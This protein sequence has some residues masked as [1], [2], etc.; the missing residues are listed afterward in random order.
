MKKKGLQSFQVSRL[1]LSDQVAEQIQHVIV[2]GGLRPGDKLPSE[3]ELGEQLGVS[4][5]VVRE[6][7]KALQERGLVKILTGSGTYVSEVE[8]DVV[9]Q[10]IELYV[11][12]RKHKYRDLLEIRKTLEVEIAGLAAERATEE[13]IERLGVVLERMQEAFPTA[14]TDAESLEEFVLADMQFHQYLAQASHN[15][16]LP[17]LLTPIADLL[18]EFSRK[19]SSLPSAPQSAHRYHKA[20]L[21]CVRSGDSEKCR[22]VMREHISST[23]DFIEQ[24]ETTDS[25]SIQK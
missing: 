19:A 3:R 23:E 21:E 2:N 5:T 13:D 6:A 25:N 24:L 18:L 15:S 1:K 7:T 11:R 12:G 4:R 20:I 17:L 8:S 9:T 14:Q 22:D 16:L 10:S